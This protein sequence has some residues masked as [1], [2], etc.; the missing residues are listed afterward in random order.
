M[1]TIVL[2]IMIMLLQSGN[3]ESMTLTIRNLCTSTVALYDNV[4]S[5]NLK[6]GQ[7]MTRQLGP[8]FQGMF[9]AGTNPQATRM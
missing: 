2:W 3:T 4:V 7:S 1:S 8:G 6:V 5:E 9:R